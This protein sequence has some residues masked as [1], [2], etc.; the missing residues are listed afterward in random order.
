M[1]M[2]LGDLGPQEE[3]DWVAIEDVAGFITDV[4]GITAEVSESTISGYFNCVNPRTTTWQ[5]LLPVI[6]G[7]Y[8]DRIHKKVTFEEWVR[9]LEQSA[10]GAFDQAA[11]LKENRGLKLLDAYRGFLEQ[12][13]SGRTQVQFSTSRGQAF[14]PTMAKMEAVTPE[15]MKNWCAQ[16]DT[17]TE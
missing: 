15:M 7:H 14:S 10:G 11:E 6:Q 16:W 3:L 8:A 1:G 12:K 4:A 9:A 13:L 5:T 17:N 2:I